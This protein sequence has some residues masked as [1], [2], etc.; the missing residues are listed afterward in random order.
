MFGRNKSGNRRVNHTSASAHQSDADPEL[1]FTQ[2][3]RPIGTKRSGHDRF[4][5]KQTRGFLHSKIKENCGALLPRSHKGQSPAAY[6]RL[7][8]C[9][10]SALIAGCVLQ[11][12]LSRWRIGEK[13]S[14][15]LFA[16]VI[17]SKIVI[18]RPIERCIS[19]CGH[20]V[21]SLRSVCY[22]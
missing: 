9:A 1:N 8:V 3:R 10:Q 4:S 13:I 18:G 20:C 19:S 5:C 12:L 17:A 11:E 14:T 21:C 2:S 7:S 22:W 6:M 16:F 15:Y